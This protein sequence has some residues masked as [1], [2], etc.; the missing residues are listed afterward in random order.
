LASKKEEED[1]DEDEDEEEGAA[2]IDRSRYIISLVGKA[3]EAVAPGV[4]R[5]INRVGD[6][7]IRVY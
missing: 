6:N 2:I 1:E 4:S 5:S 7:C 3:T